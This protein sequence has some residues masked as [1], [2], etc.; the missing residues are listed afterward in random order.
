MSGIAVI[1]RN[2]GTAGQAKTQYMKIH[3]GH[4]YYVYIVTNKNKT[5]LYTG[6]TNDLYRRLQEHKE[7]SIP[8][9]HPSFAGRY[10]SYF[11]IV[12]RKI[13]A[14][15]RCYCKREG[16]KRMA[17]GKEGIAHQFDKF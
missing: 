5:V 6:I 15:A 8:F 1:P 2:E 16:N 12:L 17:E 11:F 9:G 3:D 13:S 7:N 10:N 4:N 14:G